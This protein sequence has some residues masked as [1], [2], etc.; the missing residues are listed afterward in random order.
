MRQLQFMVFE[1]LSNVLQHSQATTL[2]I[3]AEMAG[4]GVCLRIV[5]NGRGFDAALPP[6]KGLLSMRERATAIGVAV[7]IDSRPGRTVVEIRIP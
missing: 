5:D 7:S 2:A 1:A 6:R 4:G 3:E